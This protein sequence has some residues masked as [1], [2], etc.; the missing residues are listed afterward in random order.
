VHLIRNSFASVAWKD[1]KAILPSIKT[2]YR[3]RERRRGRS[4][5]CGFRGKW[6][7]RY[8][9]IGQILQ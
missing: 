9:A 8:P 2:I 4:S 3:G 5:P 6:D 1:R 7:K